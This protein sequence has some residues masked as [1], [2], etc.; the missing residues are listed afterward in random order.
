MWDLMRGKGSASIKLSFE[1]IG[2]KFNWNGKFFAVWGDEEVL[3]F[4]LGMI[5][6]GKLG[7]V[8]DGKRMKYL[9]L[10]WWNEGEMDY[11]FVGSEDKICRIWEFGGEVQEGDEKSE[12]DVEKNGNQDEQDEEEDED[13][14]DLLPMKEVGRLIGHTNR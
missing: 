10:S 14:K 13:E 1:A 4:D 3:I 5:L 8:M 2:I 7:K 12:R 6:R 9:D 11:L